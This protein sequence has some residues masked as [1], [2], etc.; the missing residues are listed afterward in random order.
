SLTS[1]M[2]S[3][4]IYNGEKEPEEIRAEIQKTRAN[5]SETVNIIQERLSPERLKE[6]AQDKIRDATIGRIEEMAD[7][8]N[9]KTR[10]A[11]YSIVETIKH[12][13]VPAALA[14]LGLGWLLVEGFRSSGQHH[15]YQGN[16]G[17]Y[18]TRYYQTGGYPVHQGGLSETWSETQEKVGE[19]WSGAQEKVGEIAG[20]TREQVAEIGSQAREKVEQL[21]QQVQDQASQ[22]MDQVSQLGSQAREKA[23]HL[24]YQAREQAQWAKSQFWQTME[25]NPLMV[26]AAALALGLVVGLSV[27]ETRTENRLMGEARDNLMDKAQEMGQDTM[28]KVQN[29]AESVAQEAQRVAKEEAEN[30]ELIKPERESFRSV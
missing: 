4:S 27:P 22:T 15:S 25:E 28:Q 10:S 6:Q 23:E 20:Q 29:V 8:V 26:G 24:S 30:Q 9:R 16:G 21:T 11:S 14:G 7:N 17:T 2:E 3:S 19:T 13:P 18:Q 1:G 12:N 5:I